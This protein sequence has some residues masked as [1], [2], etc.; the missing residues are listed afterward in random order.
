MRILT[1]DPWH[2]YKDGP[3]HYVKSPWS[4]HWTQLSVL[5]VADMEF[6]AFVSDDGVHV[7]SASKVIE[8][9]VRRD[10]FC[11]PF[12]IFSYLVVVFYCHQYESLSPR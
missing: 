4:F 5:V 2:W 1:L 7:Y 9:D 8:V 11:L 12:I 3:Q 6:V 10:E